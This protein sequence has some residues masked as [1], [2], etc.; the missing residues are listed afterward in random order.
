MHFTEAANHRLV[1]RWMTFDPE[2]GVLDLELVQDLEQPLLVG[3]AP[4]MNGQAVH[5]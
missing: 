4:C 1:G 5:R 3:L 2:A